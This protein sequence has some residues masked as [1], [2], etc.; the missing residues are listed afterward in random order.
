MSRL[1]TRYWYLLPLL[2]FVVFL[3][4]RVEE[5]PPIITEPTIDMHKT[6]SDYYLSDF[7]TRKFSATGQVEYIVSGAALAHYPDDDRSEITKPRLELHRSGTTW[8]MQS[9]KGRFDTEPDLFQLQG[10]VTVK[11][12]SEVSEPLTIKTQ[13]LTIATE[14]NQVNTDDSIEI[15]APTWRLQAKGLRTAIDEG[16]LQLLSDVEGRYELPDPQPQDR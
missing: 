4:D 15:V 12:S 14:S 6:Q 11:R 3:L 10:N 8:Y 13:S 5:P 16:T 1:W 7:V 2:I 9:S